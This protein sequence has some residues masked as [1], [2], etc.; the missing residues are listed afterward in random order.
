MIDAYLSAGRQ[1]LRL[2]WRKRYASPAYDLPYLTECALAQ[3]NN[4]L[5]A[6]LETYLKQG[7]TSDSKLLDI[8]QV[9]VTS[10]KIT[11]NDIPVLI[12]TCTTQEVLIF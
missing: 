12:A 5:W 10:R 9:D 1:S 3:T 4:V 11:E 6:T 8:R 2:W 7:L